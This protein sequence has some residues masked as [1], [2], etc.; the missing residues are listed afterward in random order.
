MFEFKKGRFLIVAG[1]LAS[2]ASPCLAQGEPAAPAAAPSPSTNAM[3]NLIRLLVQ[4]GTITQAN[5]EALLRQAETEAGQARTASG[6][7]PPTA[8]GSIRVP[9]V[10]ETVRNQIRDEIKADVMKQAQTEGWAAPDKAAPNW[11]SN[12][13]LSA[14]F[15]MRSESDLFSKDNANDIFD[16]GAINAT[17][18][19]FDFIKNNNNIPLINTR[20]DRI[21]RLRLR[22]RIG[23]EY[24]ISKFA[25]IGV[26]LATGD[27]NS[28]IST[29]QILGGGLAKRS[30]WLDQGYLKLTPTGWASAS[31]GRFSNPF[32]STD[33]VFDRDVNFDGV[34]VE[35]SATPM[36][37]EGMT[38]ALR[39]GAF[40]LDFGSADYPTIKQNKR[41][42]AEKWLF[43]GQIEGGYEF[44][45]GIEFHAAAAYYNF[46]NVQGQLSEPCETFNGSQIS[47]GFNDPVECTTDGTRAFFPRKGNTLFFI[48]QLAIPPSDTSGSPASNRQY[49]GLV[50]RYSLLDLNAS[51]AVSI[52]DDIKATLHGD[53]VRNLAYK[54]SD[55]CRYGVGPNGIPFTNVVAVNNNDNACTATD[56]AKVVSGNQGYL[57]RLSVGHKKPRKWGEWNVT[58]DYRYLQ[59]DA[60]LDSLTDS[61]F[62]LGGTNTKG[63]T[64]A[65]SLGLFD[66][67]TLTGRWMSANEITGR[68]FAIDVFQFD[69]S[70]EF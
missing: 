27:D 16:Y 28:P 14:D 39:G 38:L 69:L 35:A 55:E 6:E 20:Q 37:P 4:Q 70:A 67:V 40:P 41:K 25:M 47:T 36:L 22:A 42:Y 51:L 44:G 46:K 68:P 5:G 64:I 33:L 58:G 54:R 32:V 23:A 56:P 29:N 65:G 52:T 61:D 18:G 11:V 12:V 66:G 15:R 10:P 49:L 62:H 31:F 24:D 2:A 8:P 43:A 21:N 17:S 34:V 63:Y 45:S 59:S 19:G 7:L 57:V 26:R 13:R 48:R 50:Y 53:Y 3:V 1:L 9:Y 60:V 30:I